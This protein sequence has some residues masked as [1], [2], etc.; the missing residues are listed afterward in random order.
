MLTQRQRQLLTFICEYQTQHDVPPSFDEMR[1]ALKL[2]SKSGIHRLISGL[3]E[4]GHIRRLTHRAR[5]IEVVRAPGVA[6]AAPAASAALLADNVV[7]GSFRPLSRPSAAATSGA[8]PGSTVVSLPLFGRIAA[9]TPIEAI[10]DTSSTIA[11]PADFVGDGEHYVLA[12]VGDSMIDAGIY[13]GDLVVIRRCEQARAGDIVVALIEER[14]VTLKRFRQRGAAIALEAA[15]PK[16]EVRIFRPD[17]VRVQG[18]L[19]GLLRR[20]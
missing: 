10:A 5:A 20:Y 7:V 12:I 9:G 15:N 18:R 3:E 17:Q 14:E 1:V 13:D 2:R 4:R 8:A 6:A 11:V 16:Y 19:V